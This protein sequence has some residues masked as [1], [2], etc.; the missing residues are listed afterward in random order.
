MFGEVVDNEG[1]LITAANRLLNPVLAGVMI[2]AVLSA[3]MSTADSQ[4]LVAASAIVHDTG[5]PAA[6][7]RPLF[8]SRLI[9]TAISLFALMVVFWGDDKIFTQVL[10][11]FSAAGAAF[12]PQLLAICL[13][14][15]PSPARI[16]V[17]MMTGVGL[18]LFAK[19]VVAESD[20]WQAHGMFFEY[21]LPTAVTALIVFTS[22][23]SAD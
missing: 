19:F 14:W 16:L 18:V 1:I 7:K 12:G 4:L 9:I 23:R 21:A 13:G 2:A 20:E 3:I 15:K 10:F 22:K 5:W 17:S 8:Y 6:A 11:A